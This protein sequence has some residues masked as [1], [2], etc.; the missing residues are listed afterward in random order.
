VDELGIGVR[1]APYEVTGPELQQAIERL[2]AD[3]ALQERL[4]R[5]A[6]RLQASPGT[7]R[8]ADLIERL[9]GLSR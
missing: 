9:V 6:A 4:E 5:I 7:V 1:L 8:A 2:L 3:T